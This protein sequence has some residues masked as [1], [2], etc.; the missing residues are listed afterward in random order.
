[1][2]QSARL[3]HESASDKVE[4]RADSG[5]HQERDDEIHHLS[6]PR[7]RRLVRADDILDTL[8]RIALLRASTVVAGGITLVGT[9]QSAN[10]CTGLDGACVRKAVLG[11]G[12]FLRHFGSEIQPKSSRMRALD[13]VGIRDTNV[14]DDLFAI[15]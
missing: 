4:H 3:L 15:L 7:R 10:H 9:I 8:V 6:P 11:P 5:E 12:H 2:L 1:M 13:R 14:F